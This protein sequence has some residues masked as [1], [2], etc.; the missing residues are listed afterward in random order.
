MGVLDDFAADGRFLLNVDDG[1]IRPIF[2][3]VPE[4]SP[5]SPAVS[6]PD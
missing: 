5:A 2:S 4:S 3:Q 6:M 1:R